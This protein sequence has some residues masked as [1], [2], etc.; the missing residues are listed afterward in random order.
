MYEQFAMK[1]WP[2][3]FSVRMLRANESCDRRKL[4]INIIVVQM[5]A[6]R[7]VIKLSENEIIFDSTKLIFI[8]KFLTSKSPRNGDTHKNRIVI[9]PTQLNSTMRNKSTSAQNTT[10]LFMVVIVSLCVYTFSCLKL[11]RS[12]NQIHVHE[13]D[14]WMLR[15]E[16]AKELLEIDDHLTC[17]NLFDFDGVVWW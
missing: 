14:K 7:D 13:T 9:K 5:W 4:S 1:L 11:R 17:R 6:A 3:A 12:T 8:R 2:K 10:V 16:L 15:T